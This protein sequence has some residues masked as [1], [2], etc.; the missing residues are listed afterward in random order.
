V[1]SIGFEAAGREGIVVR[2]KLGELGVAGWGVGDGEG[3]EWWRDSGES[4]TGDEFPAEDDAAAAA[5]AGPVA[6]AGVLEEAEV[7]R[8]E[9]A[10]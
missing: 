6:A 10:R 9:D 7:D 3:D 4:E 5:A 1:I 8:P 2:P